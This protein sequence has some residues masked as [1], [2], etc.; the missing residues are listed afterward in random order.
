MSPLARSVL[1]PTELGSLGWLPNLQIL[2]VP[3]PSSVLKPIELVSLVGC[4]QLQ[5]MDGD[6]RE[7]LNGRAGGGSTP[8]QLGGFQNRL[9]WGGRFQNLEIFLGYAQILELPPP[10][11]RWVSE[12]TE[13]AGRVVP[14]PQLGHLAF[15][16]CSHAFA[17]VWFLVAQHDSTSETLLAN[18]TATAR[19]VNRQ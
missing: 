14:P 19:L 13:L 9:S 8:P 4:Q 6:T 10:P 2:E 1:K 18:L 16:Q 11:A 12:P 17:D 7:T 15:P 5:T 3:P